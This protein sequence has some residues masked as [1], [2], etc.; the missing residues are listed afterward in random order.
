MFILKWKF[1]SVSRTR[2]KTQNLCLRKADNVECSSTPLTFVH[3]ESYPGEC[4]RSR[5]SKLLLQKTRTISSSTKL[6]L[7]PLRQ[8]GEEEAKS[9]R[10][11]LYCIISLERIVM[12][13]LSF[14]IF[15]SSDHCSIGAVLICHDWHCNLQHQSLL[16]LWFG[17]PSLINTTHL[18]NQPHPLSTYLQGVACYITQLQTFPNQYQQHELR[19]DMIRNV[20]KVF[21]VGRICWYVGKT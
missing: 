10:S 1:H 9:D 14:S 2:R 4:L 15:W 19:Q 5:A 17:R 11:R 6:K 7:R 13:S 12:V 16:F 3:S 18:S 21:E 8:A 20:R